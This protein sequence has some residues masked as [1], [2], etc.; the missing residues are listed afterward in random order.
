MHDDIDHIDHIDR[1]TIRVGVVDSGY[2]ASLGACVVE[3]R[4][5]AFDDAGTLQAGAVEADRLGHGSAVCTTIAAAAPDA[6]LLVAQVFEARGVTSAAQIAHAIRWLLTRHVHLI[7]LS[8]GVRADRDTLRD[9]CAQAVAQRVAVFASSPAQGM[10]VFPASYP[11]VV[12]VT[13][14]ARCAP[15]QWSWLDSPQADFGARVSSG[16]SHAPAGASIACA[17]LSGHA[18]GWLSRHREADTAALLDHLRA[19]AAYVGV[20]RRSCAS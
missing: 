14:D 7:N 9:A 4:R 11:G 8:L 2:P 20:E 16:A 1:A 13:G 3:A 12:R 10:P 5:F 17:A 6:R 19:N 15:G 18:A